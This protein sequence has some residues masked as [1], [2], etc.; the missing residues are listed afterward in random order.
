MLAYLFSGGALVAH[1]EDGFVISKSGAEGSIAAFARS[2]SLVYGII[3]AG[4]ALFIGWAGGVIFR[5]D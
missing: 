5:R 1:A 4:L 2:Q 3:C